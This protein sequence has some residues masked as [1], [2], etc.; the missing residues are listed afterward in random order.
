MKRTAILTGLVLGLL[1]SASPLRAAGGGGKGP[2]SF[3]LTA[4]G[5]GAG[6]QPLAPSLTWSASRR[7]T[8]YLVQVD[9]D[10]LFGAPLVY[11]ASVSA[12]SATVPSGFLSAGTTYYWRVLAGGTLLAS[13]APFSFR[14]A[15]PEQTAPTVAISISPSMP[16]PASA[17]TY[18]ATASDPSGISE[19]RIFV[20]GVNVA[21]TTGSGGCAYV[22]G[23]Y[24]FGSVH[25]FFA[26]ARDASAARN[27]AQT[28]TNSFTV[29]SGPVTTEGILSVQYVNASTL[30]AIGGTQFLKSTDGGVT[31]SASQVA[32][33]GLYNYDV[34]FS[35]PSVGTVVGG[36]QYSSSNFV[37]RTLDGGQTWTPQSCGSGNLLAGVSFCSDSTGT[38]VGAGRGV[39]RTTNGGATWTQQDT[40]L[41][42]G[43]LM[44]VR[45]ID[46]LNVVAVGNSVYNGA[47][48]RTRDGGITW[49]LALTPMRLQDVCVPASNLMVA[50]GLDRVERST[51]GGSTFSS[52]AISAG[53]TL[54]GV[55][56]GDARIGFAVSNAGTIY[57][58]T[59]GG[60]SWQPIRNTGNAL[61]GVSC[62][63]A[64]TAV[65]VGNAGV[66]LQTKDGGAT[67][68]RRN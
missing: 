30:V 2:G 27:S 10:A 32:P 61:W 48:C 7:T 56:F 63:D 49:S 9:S 51:D 18:T 22:G 39:Y 4:P 67:W 16:T 11:S 64:S 14:T 12:T 60:V 28:A 17:V 1:C 50:V 26:V 15:G 21:T 33:S 65:V 35:S 43:A 38:I 23:P 13:N 40:G 42:I 34:C 44:A 54:E 3:T 8:T 29:V 66:I 59:D 20:D 46:A 52:N 19:L 6:D 45:Q 25:T 24:A 68:I 58:T 53:Y 41:S 47:V 36:Y 31:W 37:L 57:R 62:L 5:N 55:S